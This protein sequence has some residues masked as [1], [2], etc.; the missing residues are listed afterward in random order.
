MD[1]DL[2]SAFLSFLSCHGYHRDYDMLDAFFY[3]LSQYIPKQRLFE[4]MSWRRPGEDLGCVWIVIMSSQLGDIWFR[5]CLHTE[6]L[7]NAFLWLASD[8]RLE[9]AVYRR[10]VRSASCL[11]V[12]WRY[13]LECQIRNKTWKME[14]DEHCLV[15]W[16]NRKC[17]TWYEFLSRY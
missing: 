7:C 1:L 14:T 9:W 12:F 11:L 2:A 8:L 15:S 13:W 4:S 6:V 17:I 10:D 3:R 5:T 16:S